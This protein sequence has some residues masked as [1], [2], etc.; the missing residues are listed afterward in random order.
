MMQ[1]NQEHH[2]ACHYHLYKLQS[3]LQHHGT[4][5][6][7]YTSFYQ[8]LKYHQVLKVQYL[9]YAFFYLFILLI[10]AV[11]F[12]FAFDKLNL[13]PF[14]EHTTRMATAYIEGANETGSRNLVTGIVLDFR[15]YDTLG[16]ATVLF[17]AVIGILTILR[18]KG[19]KGKK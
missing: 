2:H 18:M 6:Y 17:T 10:F 15:A 8:I 13:N 3:V 16:E 19:K 4:A 9:Q 11:I 5:Y 1:E 14:G 7:Y 12:F